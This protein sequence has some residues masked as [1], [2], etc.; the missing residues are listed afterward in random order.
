VKL[1]KEAPGLDKPPF[2]GE[3]GKKLFESVSAEGWE[4][5]LEH[6]FTLH[7]STVYRVCDDFPRIRR[8]DFPDGGLPAGVSK[9]R[10]DVLLSNCSDFRLSTSEEESLISTLA[11][12]VDAA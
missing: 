7:G 1:H 10:Y 3:L 5:W 2:P 12:S 6:R 8:S 9:L 11:R 4:L